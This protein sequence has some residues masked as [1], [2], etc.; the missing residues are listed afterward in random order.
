MIRLNLTPFHRYLSYLTINTDFQSNA[1][2]HYDYDPNEYVCEGAL[3]LYK[4]YINWCENR[5]YSK[6]FKYTNTRFGL[7]MK[8]MID[9]IAIE[10]KLLTK[11]AIYIINKE[12]LK[13]M[14]ISK[15][16]FDEDIY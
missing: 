10:K 8:K 11:N 14:L 9:G 7:E 13:E 16:L 3:L 5:N 4:D 2:N 12:K 6:E 15:K 1:L